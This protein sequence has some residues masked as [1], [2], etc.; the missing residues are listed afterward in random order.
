MLKTGYRI[1]AFVSAL[2]LALIVP[3]FPRAQESDMTGLGEAVMST[4]V[5]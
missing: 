5:A 1:P 4:S 3:E 2:C